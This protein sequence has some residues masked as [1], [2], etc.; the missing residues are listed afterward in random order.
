ML[1]SPDFF[2]IG[3]WRW[4]SSKQAPETDEQFD[5]RWINFFNQEDLDSWELR[6]GVNELYG[7]DLVPEPKIVVAMLK[8]ARRLDDVAMAI[9]VLEAVKSKAAGDLEV[10]NYVMDAIRPTLEELGLNTP[11]ELGLE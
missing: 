8:A 7:H 11:S 9:R 4:Y 6:R 3:Q 10:Y 1:V 2:I 5:T